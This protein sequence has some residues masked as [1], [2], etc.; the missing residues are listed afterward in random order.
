[1]ADDVIVRARAGD[2]QA[3]ADLVAPYRPE[4]LAHCYR[5][6]GSVQDAED[7][8]QET[9]V[10]AWHGLA[11][12]EGRSSVR[13][14]LY[15][16]A[17]NRCLDMARS[18]RRRPD[19]NVS[20]RPWPPLEPT[21]LK[22]AVRLDPYPDEL[23]AGLPD[24]TPGPDARYEAREAISL[25]FVAALQLLP[26]RQRVVLVL[27]DVLGFRTAE[28]AVIIGASQE[29]VTSALKR[30][31]SSLREVFAGGAGYAG[32]P[33][34]GSAAERAVAERLT[35]AYEAGRVDDLVALL[36]G[37]V[38]LSM[39]QAAPEYRG[40]D[41]VARF[42]RAYVFVPGRSYRLVPTRANGQLAFGI[43]LCDPQGGAAGACGLLVLT[44]TGDKI[45]G[46]T[47][48]GENAVASLGLPHVLTSFDRG[49]VV[50]GRAPLTTA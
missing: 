1:V 12:F 37:D 45:S 34:V 28:A 29:S 11:G 10:S 35:R 2:E 39:P 47:R 8:V 16:I 24:G 23:L 21:R 18:A 25:A 3:F 27:R 6:L 17:T 36:A 41:L 19:T 20:S 49:V 32:P 4:L 26:P 31:R 33:A 13:T 46:L 38:L 50:V 7:Q 40:R 43:Y 48:F 14:W 44:L 15:R 30:A 22:E 42:L 5:I 9:L